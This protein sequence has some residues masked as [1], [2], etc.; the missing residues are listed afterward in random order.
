MITK[1]MEE[2]NEEA[3]HK[4]F[5]DTELTTNKQTRDSK[6]EEA[7]ELTAES[8]K[9][10]ADIAQLAEAISVLGEEIAALD[11]M[12]A[13]A[14]ANRQ[15]ENA[16][17]TATIEDSKVA[18]AATQQAMAVLKEFYDKAGGGGAAMTQ[19]AVQPAG[20][21]NYD[22][23]AIQILEKPSLVQKGQASQRVHQPEMGAAEYTGMG[24]GGVMGMLEVI[25]SDFARLLSETTA[26]EQEAASAFEKLSNDS[27][28][29]KAVKTTESKS[30]TG[31]KTRKESA[32][33]STKKDLAAAMDYYEK[34]KPS[35]VD[36]GVSYEERVA[37]RKEEIESLQ[38][39]LK[40][41][42]AE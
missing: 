5:C 7:D 20:P 38:E 31:E 11:A 25:E 13:E 32:L 26:G 3:E 4:G 21:I 15:A 23:R 14:T 35:C 24:N 9:L 34:L 19:E 27:A 37:R 36:A 33:A 40:I 12:M 30:K 22:S 41:L 28:E 1:L 2:A 42:S 6:T 16:K 10:T 17:N 8:E 29:N 39:A 18:Q